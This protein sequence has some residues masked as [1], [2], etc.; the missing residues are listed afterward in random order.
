MANSSKEKTDLDA[1]KEGLEEQIAALRN[2]IEGLAGAVAALKEAFVTAFRI[3]R[4]LG[5]KRRGADSTG[6]TSGRT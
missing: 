3:G 2:D 1:A 5:G 6:T 4:R